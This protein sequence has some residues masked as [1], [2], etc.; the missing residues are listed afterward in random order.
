M[1]P[2]ELQEL[3]AALPQ[4][5]E[6]A[7]SSP[8]NHDPVT[9]QGVKDAQD[10]RTAGDGVPWDAPLAMAAS[11]GPNLVHNMYNAGGQS[12]EFDPRR[13]YSD[14]LEDRVAGSRVAGFMA[15]LLAPDVTDALG[16]VG[17]GMSI[18]P[19]LR[20]SKHNPEAV[21]R[22]ERAL[23]NPEG[24]EGVLRDIAELL[25]G[26]RNDFEGGF[27]PRPGTSV[28]LEKYDAGRGKQGINVGTLYNENAEG[29]GLRELGPLL[30][31]LDAHGVPAKT[32]A[33]PF[34]H[35]R[36]SRDKLVDLYR[37]A[38]FESNP[39]NPEVLSRKPVPTEAAARSREMQRRMNRKSNLLT[40]LMQSLSNRLAPDPSRR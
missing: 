7:T 27:S 29:Q 31:L 16:P 22:I 21:K 23:E 6:Y 17:L 30:D 8:R 12:V 14:V 5:L 34:G 25:P 20:A 32:R 40:R 1:T 37:K 15:D 36:L 11:V 18:F 2:E 3:L 39:W 26:Q 33:A 28:T 38:G 9:V 4:T 35:E 19:F 24:A 13:T 10:L